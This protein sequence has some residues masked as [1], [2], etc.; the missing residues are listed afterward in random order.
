MTQQQ[1]QI[2]SYESNEITDIPE[3]LEKVNK[4]IQ[5][6]EGS[7]IQLMDADLICGE[8]HINQAITQAYKAFDEG[9]NFAKDKGLEICVRASAQK[10]ISQAI[11]LLGIKEKGNITAVYINTTSQQIQQ[12]EQLL[13]ER[14]DAL[15]EEYDYEKICEAY[16][17]ENTDNVVEYINEKIALL[18]LKN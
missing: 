17:L 4:I 16:N 8:K 13:S 12:T 2:R 3:F 9:Q 18:A 7:I 10:Q 11:K 14:N 15:L 6:N 1:I 5:T